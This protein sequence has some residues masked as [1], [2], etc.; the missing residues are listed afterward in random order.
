M[1]IAS[2]RAPRPCCLYSA[3]RLLDFGHV[4]LDAQATALLR[5]LHVAALR[6]AAAALVRRWPSCQIQ[7]VSMAVTLPG[8]APPDVREHRERHIEVVVRVRAPGQA[9]V[10][11]Q[12]APRAPSRP[13]SRNAGRPAECRPI[14]APANVHHLAPVGG[15]HVGGSGQAGGAAEF[16]HH[17]AAREH[18]SFGAARV[19]GIGHTPCI[20]RHRRIASF[21]SQPPFGSSVTRACGKRSCNARIASTSSSPRSTPPFSLKSWKP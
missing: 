19:F 9:P 10:A 8:A 4:E 13:W 1:P 6:S 3:L 17:L 11:A 18:R 14:A 15:D 7:C 16:R 21:S 12:S 2:S 5:H 20:S